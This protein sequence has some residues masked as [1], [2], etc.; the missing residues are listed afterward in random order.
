MSGDGHADVALGLPTLNHFVKQQYMSCLCGRAVCNDMYP[1][2]V[3]VGA[4]ALYV[5]KQQ[6]VY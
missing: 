5:H 6:A 1:Q 4:A 3:M 2:A